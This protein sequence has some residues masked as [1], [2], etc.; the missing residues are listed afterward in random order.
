MA[1]SMFRVGPE[2][3]AA[4]RLAIAEGAFT[5]HQTAEDTAYG[6]LRR[7]AHTEAHSYIATLRHADAYLPVDE[8]R[9]VAVYIHAFIIGALDELSHNTLL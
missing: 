2:A 6:D 5:L 1:N 8:S 9:L 3:W 7:F 4:G